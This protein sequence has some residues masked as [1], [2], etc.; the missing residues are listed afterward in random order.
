MTVKMTGHINEPVAYEEPGETKDILKE[1][2]ENLFVEG[3]NPE[4][5]IDN[6]TDADDDL[7]VVYAHRIA[8]EAETKDEAIK[9]IQNAIKENRAQDKPL[10]TNPDIYFKTVEDAAYDFS[11]ENFVDK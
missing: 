1:A 7:R 4:F 9:K 3:A 6:P 5:Y 2:K 8:A 11:E 10:R